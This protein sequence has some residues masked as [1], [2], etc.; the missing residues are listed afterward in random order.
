[1]NVGPSAGDCGR[2]SFLTKMSLERLT[3]HAETR[4]FSKGVRISGGQQLCEAAYLILS[5]GCELRRTLPDGQQRV[6]QNLGP[7]TAFGGLEKIEGEEVWTT[8][9]AT[10]DT[11]VLRMNC[12]KL[13]SLR[14]ESNSVIQCSEA[15]SLESGS[16]ATATA[17]TGTEIVSS[18]TD[19]VRSAT[20]TTRAERRRLPRQ[21]VTLAFLSQQLPA[22]T[23]SEQL[24]RGLCTETDSN[25]VL[26]RF[27]TQDSSLAVA[28]PGLP[29]PEFFLNG[30]FHMPSRV[31]KTI[32]GFFS[33][34]LGIKDA[35]PPSPAGIASLVSHLS[36][37]FR[38]V[39]IESIPSDS[40]VPWLIDLLVQSDLGYLFLPPTAQAV[41]H[42]DT[43]IREVCSVNN[44]AGI[45]ASRRNCEF[46]VVSGATR[47]GQG[48]TR[49]GQDARPVQLKPIGCL[50]ANG[51][52][53]GFDLLAPSM[54][55][56]LHLF[57]RDC[58]NADLATELPP[59]SAR[60]NADIRRLAR[61]I[62]GHL[63]GL[64]LSSGAAKGFAHIG[65]IQVLEENGIDVD[66]VAGASMGAYVGSIWAHGSEGPELE[67]IA[68]EMEGRWALW[69]L[70]DP[71]FPPRQ[72]F[73]RGYAVKKRL[74]R[75][76]GDSHFS[77]MVRPLRIVAGNLAT[78][79]RVVFSGGQVAEAVHAS[80]AVPGICVPITIGNETYIDGGIV[81]PLPV[82]V[83]REMGVTRVIAVD[84]IPTPDRIRMGLQLERELAQN[85]VSRLRKFF[86]KALPV[87]Q[88]LN[89][90]APG[91]LFEILM[92]SIQ[93]A[94]IRVA[95]ASCQLADVVLRPDIG[96]D[97][98]GDCAKPGRFIALGREIALRHLAEIKELVARK[99]A[100]SY[101]REFTPESVA[102]VD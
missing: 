56:P 4:Y 17:S 2:L 53:R 62:G 30:E 63:V 8:A 36:R 43:V 18:A 52:T 50:P 25:V 32:G 15:T 67:R 44:G 19:P 101:E 89:Y 102:T 28:R 98:W 94:Q 42:L 41:T 86:H 39:L 57:V 3:P 46:N 76:I 87:N 77:D 90:F 81:D 22:A 51:P 55:C 97:R 88:Q 40:P 71:V 66:V 33:V 16:G 14:A 1:M 75:S 91:N 73:L 9:F 100:S 69:T 20:G 31:N 79:E 74:M 5:G 54:S 27:A 10:A 34:T 64:A 84:V 12:E 6:L 48:A 23:I 80:V 13:D 78:L 60:F 24:A 11:I 96:S 58:Q 93:A 99:E 45:A 37:H 82:D 7:G 68:R 61:E 49:T 29:A 26:V 83:L 85:N 70:I 65:V 59:A 47:T 95:E 92:R 35:E 38:H 21:V 72:G